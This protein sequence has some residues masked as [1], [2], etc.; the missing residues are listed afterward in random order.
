MSGVQTEDYEPDFGG[1]GEDER[2]W[3]DVL[4]SRRLELG[5]YVLEYS[6]VLIYHFIRGK[7]TLYKYTFVKIDSYDSC[8]E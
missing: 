4:E 2:W 8:G 5:M 3:H 1:W 7:R 6:V